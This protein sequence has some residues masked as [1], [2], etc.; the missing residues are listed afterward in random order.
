MKV[1]LKEIKYAIAVS[2]HLNF[3]KASQECNISS[4][5]LSN[6]IKNLENK[7]NFEI[8]E[9]NNKKVILTS[10]GKEFLKEAKNIIV[11]VKDLEK[12]GDSSLNSLSRNISIGIIPTIGAYLLPIVLPP[13]KH[14]YPKSNLKIVEAQS[15][16]LLKKLDS[17]EIDI[18]I[19][20]LPYLLKDFETLKFWEEDFFWITHKEYSGF[21]DSVKSKDI[22]K[23]DLM[24]LE[25][26]HCLKDQ[27]ADLCN[28]KTNSNINMSASG[29]NTL[30]ELVAGKMGSTLV[31]ELS[32]EQLVS[33]NPLLRK[34]HLDE[35]SPHRELAFAF[36]KSY[37]AQSDILLLKNLFSY[38]LSKYFNRPL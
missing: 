35:P 36:R 19:I 32:L 9:R 7:I 6:A 17:G 20:A 28:L 26:G 10:L 25:D 24:L 18:G 4:S 34:S 5:T 15:E 14:K 27:V 8:F 16:L 2:K 21:S 13:L 31:P 30:V 29:L 22:K 3:R 37:K 11:Q 1:T 33:K 23:D 38:E 12:L